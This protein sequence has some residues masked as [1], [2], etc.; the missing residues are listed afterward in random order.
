MKT[1]TTQEELDVLKEVAAGEEVEIT[2]A[3]QLRADLKVFGFLRMVSTLDLSLG[4]RVEARGSSRVEA[5]GSSRVEAW[6]SSRV[7]AWGSSRVEAWDSSRVE[8]WGSSSVE[9]WD[10]SRVVARDSSSV[11]ARGSSRVEALGDAFVRIVSAAV[12]V[13]LN[14]TAIAAVSASLKVK[15]K[16]AAHATICKLPELDWFDANGVKKAKTIT[17]YKRVSAAFKTQEGTERETCWPV[18]AT[19][20]H[21]AWNPTAEECGVGKFHACSRPF[22]CDEFRNTPGDVYIAIRVAAADLYEWKNPKYPHKIAFRRGKVLYQCD[23]DG[24]RI[25]KGAGKK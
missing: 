4:F 23:I 2:A 15:I 13:V 18:G 20:D 22:F 7:E 11:V 8:A 17:L 1:I 19:L 3:L 14:A 12:K 21:P 6:D 10:S 16:K 24:E 5:R 9:A 25:G